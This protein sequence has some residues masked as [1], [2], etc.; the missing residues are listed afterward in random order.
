[1]PRLLAYRRYPLLSSRDFMVT[2]KTCIEV[3]FF[4]SEIP[5]KKKRRLKYTVSWLSD[6]H[7]ADVTF[8][9]K[10][11][12]QRAM[13]A[14]FPCCRRIT[15]FFRMALYIFCLLRDGWQFADGGE[16]RGPRSRYTCQIFHFPFY[17]RSGFLYGNGISLFLTCFD[18]FISL[19]I[20]FAN[21]GYRFLNSLRPMDLN[22][23]REN[24]FDYLHA[25]KPE[26]DHLSIFFNI[27]ESA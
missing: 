19:Y 16:N 2:L 22:K 25:N 24:A 4:I 5:V 14:L 27:S 10:G 26:F 13:T 11:F 23:R 7:I 21:L 1:M 18:N 3:V 17:L 6:D 9:V 12:R 15:I 8:D 20:G